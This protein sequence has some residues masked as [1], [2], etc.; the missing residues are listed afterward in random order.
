MLLFKYYVNQVKKC[1]SILSALCIFLTLVDEKLSEHL[2]VF[3]G[4]PDSYYFI[5]ICKE[6]Q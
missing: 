2:F 5:L 6:M 3:P 1:K 4:I